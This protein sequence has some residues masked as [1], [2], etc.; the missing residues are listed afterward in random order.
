[1]EPATGLTTNE[2]S[3][4]ALTTNQ[5][6]EADAGHSELRV[7][8][9][10]SAN[11]NDLVPNSTRWF[12]D[13][14]QLTS[15]V[16]MANARRR[17]DEPFDE[18]A[19]P[20][21]PSSPHLSES[22]TATGYPVLTI[23]HATR[24]DSGLY[25]CQ[26]ANSVGTSE[27]LPA[28]ESCRVDV[29][30]RPSVK[31]RLFKPTKSAGEAASYSTDELVELDLRQEI[32]RPGERYVLQCEVTEAQPAKIK[33]FQWWQS[34]ERG[35]QSRSAPTNPIDRTAQLSRRREWASGQSA[36]AASVASQPSAQ[37]EEQLLMGTSESGQ[38]VLGS[39]AANFSATSYFCAASNSLGASEPSNRVRL[40]LSYTPGKFTNG[41]AI[42]GRRLSRCIYAD[43]LR[44]FLFLLLLLL[45]C[46]AV[47]GGGK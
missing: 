29:N 19:E 5:P 43:C 47:E 2:S 17:Q 36:Q 16:S 40:Q 9:I 7:Y 18:S 30:F 12:K 42:Q 20:D 24:R 44:V 33:R 15:V 27:R 21:A 45:L 22:L 28:S 37:Q 26:V 8:C 11:P 3:A 14:Q 38:L 6:A 41:Y 34:R 39:L 31:L 46:L 4:T 35:V 1:M 23:R 10:F 25:D 32:V 13:G